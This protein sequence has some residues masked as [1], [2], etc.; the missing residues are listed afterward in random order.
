[1]EGACLFQVQNASA[2]ARGSENCHE[3]ARGP[4]L[5]E[6]LTRL[7]EIEQAVNKIPTPLAYAENLYIFREHVDVV[8]RRIARQLADA[9][10]LQ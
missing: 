5:E 10:A 1:M 4:A 7:D 3:G 6:L 2:N 8:R 9:L